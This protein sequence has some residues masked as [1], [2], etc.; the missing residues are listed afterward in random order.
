[1]QQYFLNV[2]DLADPENPTKRQLV[3]IPG[4][5]VG[6]GRDGA[7]LYT[8]APHWDE[9][10]LES[11]GVEWLDVS[12]YDG[13]SA[14]LVDSV[15][16]SSH[17][18]NP[19]LVDKDIVYVGSPQTSP[20][21][22]QT[23]AEAPHDT[24]TL[25][26]YR[27]TDAGTFEIVSQTVLPAPA[28]ELRLRG[29]ILILRLSTRVYQEETWFYDVSQPGKLV[30]L[31]AGPKPNC[32]EYNPMT[33]EGSAN[34]GLWAAGGDYGV[35]RISLADD[36]NRILAIHWGMF[37][38]KDCTEYCAIRMEAR[39]GEIQLFRGI[40][41]WRTLSPEDWQELLDL[42]NLEEMRRLSAAMECPDCDDEGG[43]WVQVFTPQ[44]DVRIIFP[45]GPEDGE[46]LSPL[47]GAVSPL[48]E[49]MRGFLPRF[50]PHW[51][52][53]PSQQRAEELRR[54]QERQEEERRRQEEEQRRQEE[55]PLT[56]TRWNRDDT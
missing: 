4:A 55:E 53:W 52:G 29:E 50:H 14:S 25:T 37:E 3:N 54:Q 39:P 16:L 13:V 30:P 44:G 23:K 6:I 41:T 32:F 22:P 21:S 28:Q 46:I 33:V 43:E 26:A 20:Y 8:Q 34:D 27:L 48:A 5:L 49:K 45:R 12:A 36:L 1:M 10:T 11:D 19:I 9:E 38:G 7:L 15:P 17:W 24:N 35:P 2:V 31:G 18:G 47:A 42:V 51:P 40:S 56:T